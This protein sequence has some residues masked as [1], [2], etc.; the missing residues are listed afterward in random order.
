MD[1]KFEQLTFSQDDVINLLKDKMIKFIDLQFTSL[2]G[3][4]HHNTI[5]ANLFKRILITGYQRLMDPPFV[6]LQKYKNLT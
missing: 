6:D 3:R 5:S 1:G 2:F 4:F